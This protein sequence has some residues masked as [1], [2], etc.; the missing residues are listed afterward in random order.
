[1]IFSRIDVSDLQHRLF[2]EL[3]VLVGLV[4]VFPSISFGQAPSALAD[5]ESF[6]YRTT[7]KGELR[8]YV[9]KPQRWRSGGTRS[10][11]VTFFGGGWSSGSPSN[12]MFSARWAAQ[13]G[14]VS[15]V[16]DYR[17]ADRFETT[18]REAV[19]DARLAVRWIQVHA[20]EL[21]IDPRKLVVAGSSSGGHLALWTAISEG[22]PGYP[23]EEA[24]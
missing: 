5:S 7:S 18:P 20:D 9:V 2:A 23:P 10:A 1:M 3:R 4:V 6:V 14:F 16:P 19:A 13:L 17:V 22:P 11:F 21:G 24:P 12:A 15:F 8:L